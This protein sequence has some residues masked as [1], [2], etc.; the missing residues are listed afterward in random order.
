MVTASTYNPLDYT[1]HPTP[2][3]GYRWDRWLEMEVRIER[4]VPQPDDE[5]DELMD[6]DRWEMELESRAE[7]RQYYG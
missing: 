3:P 6:A 4:P 1:T 5:A 7:N 2:R